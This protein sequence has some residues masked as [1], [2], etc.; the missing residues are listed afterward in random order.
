MVF[1]ECWV[2]MY[3]TVAMEVSGH[4]SWAMPDGAPMFEQTLR[5]MA[6]A[7]DQPDRYA[8]PATALVR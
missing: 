8:P 5:S 4:L 2:R 6:T 3:G 7:V 1:L